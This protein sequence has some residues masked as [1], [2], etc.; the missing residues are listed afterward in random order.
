L[1]TKKSTVTVNCQKDLDDLFWR[2]DTT[3]SDWTVMSPHVV[4]VTVESKK[5]F[6]RPNLNGNCVIAA[7]VT[8]FARIEMDKAIRLLISCGIKVLYTDTDS[9]IFVLKEGQKNPLEEG[10]CFNQFK[11]EL[12]GCTILSFYTLGPKIYQ[13]TYKIIATGEIKTDTKVKGFFLKSKK[14][15][16]IIHD[17]LFSEY[18]EGY[19]KGEDLSSKVGQFQLQTLAKRTLKSVISQKILTNYGFNKRVSFRGDINSIQTLPYGYDEEMYSKHV[20]NT[21]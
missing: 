2:E 5:G 3:I 4:E 14:G 18:V 13:I 11:N 7:H 19:L 6:N 9:I 10:Q 12:S 16:E 8:A 20:L 17:K 21:M 1:S 15:K